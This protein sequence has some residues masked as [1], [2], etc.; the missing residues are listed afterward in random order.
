[1]QIDN[2]YPS[3]LQPTPATAS[4]EQVVDFEGILALSRIQLIPTVTVLTGSADVVYTLSYSEDNITYTDVTGTD[5]TGINFRYVKV[6]LD[7]SSPSGIDVIKI[8]SLRLRLDVKLKTDAGIVEITNTVDPTD[9]LFNLGFVDIQSIQ[10]TA[11]GIDR[12]ATYNFV[13]APN[14]VGASINLQD[15]LTGDRVTGTVSWNVRGV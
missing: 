11:A 13:D 1:M 15:R 12:L 14:P 6:R 2:G 10:M 5:T 9:F 7:I 3:Y 8:N 4:Y